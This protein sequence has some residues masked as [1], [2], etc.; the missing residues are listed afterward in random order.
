MFLARRATQLV[1]GPALARQPPRPGGVIRD[2]QRRLE[3]TQPPGARI[4]RGRSALPHRL[5]P[6]CADQGHGE[7]SAC[8]TCA[9]FRLV[10]V[11]VVTKAPP[12]RL[13]RC[14]VG[15]PATQDRRL[16]DEPL[17]V[18]PLSAPWLHM[19]ARTCP[20]FFFYSRHRTAITCNMTN[21]RLTAAMLRET[22]CQVAW[23]HRPIGLTQ[24][25][26]HVEAAPIRGR[27]SHHL[28]SPF[29]ADDSLMSHPR[30]KRHM[31]PA[32]QNPLLAAS[33]VWT[34]G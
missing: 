34:F 11:S 26:V 7:P 9:S 18:A 1:E 19:S 2:F 31:I 3:S 16:L 27:Q 10:S 28:L 29:A 24:P 23:H 20:I 30:H 22:A 5:G 6:A 25:S 21:I 14:C 32:V 33:H 12:R 8:S 13:D 15:Q 17:F 4:G